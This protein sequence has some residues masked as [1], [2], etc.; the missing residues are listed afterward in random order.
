MDNSIEPKWEYYKLYVDDE[1]FYVQVFE[2]GDY[3]NISHIYTLISESCDI[4]RLN[5]LTS[6]LRT[7]ITFGHA[8]A[9][10]AF[11]AYGAD[12]EYM[13]GS[14]SSGMAANIINDIRAIEYRKVKSNNA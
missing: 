12:Y 1:Y 4:N 14:K 7:L 13:G 2:E 11:K 3:C 6:D 5:K 9:T 8:S 10:E